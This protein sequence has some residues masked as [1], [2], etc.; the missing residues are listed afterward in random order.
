MS[1]ISLE[2]EQGAFWFQVVI[3]GLPDSGHAEL[4]KHVSEKYETLIPENIAHIKDEAI[5][6]RINYRIVDISDPTDTSLTSLVG[7]HALA[8]TASSDD[9]LNVCR[10]ILLKIHKLFTC[11]VPLLVLVEQPQS[12]DCSLDRPIELLGLVDLI[13]AGISNLRV[14]SICQKGDNGFDE[15]FDWLTSYFLTGDSDMQYSSLRG[16]TGTG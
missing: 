12:T 16:T 13:E 10:N 7:T 9:D 1:G 14:F 3:C 8:F 2:N 6:R 11:R 5:P 15:V 4:L